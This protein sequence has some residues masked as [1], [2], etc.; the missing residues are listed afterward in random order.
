[1]R[2][3]FTALALIAALTGGAVG[4]GAHEQEGSCPMT[5][6][7]DCCKKAHSSSNTREVSLARLCCNLNCSEPGSTGSNSST[8][9][10]SQSSMTAVA[11]AV[12][13]ASPFN[14]NP[15]VGPLPQKPQ[16]EDS[17]P[18]YIQHLALLI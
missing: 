18:K 6:L 15:S 4:M 14:R 1:M 2:K 11:L 9:F 16:S 7:P 17:N 8:S 5:K 12:P 3:W 13:N 10:S